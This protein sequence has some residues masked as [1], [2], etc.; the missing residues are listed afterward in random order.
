MIRL[1]DLSLANTPGGDVPGLYRTA[2]FTD[3]V[4]TNGGNDLVCVEAVLSGNRFVGTESRLAMVV[5]N[6]AFY[7]GNHGPS[8]E[9]F[10]I[11]NLAPGFNKATVD[12][13]NAVQVKLA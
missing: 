9:S 5:A 7:V 6:E 12:D 8:S 4:F 10:S 13:L 1:R 2:R 3:N 11:K